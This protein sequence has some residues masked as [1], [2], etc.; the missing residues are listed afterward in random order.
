MSI[1][2]LKAAYAATT[3][4]EWGYITPDTDEDDDWMNLYSRP[5][6]RSEE[7]FVT[8]FNGSTAYPDAKFIAIAN[9][10][11]PELLE[12]VDV[13]LDSLMAWE[14]EADSVRQEHAEL[15]ERIANVAQKLKGE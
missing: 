4:G 6:D 7:I 12:A 10:M 11:M 2:K 13:L 9:N 5:E 14:N 3:G 15:I 8:R 1:E